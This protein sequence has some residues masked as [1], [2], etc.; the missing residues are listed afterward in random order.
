ML[1]P[2]EYLLPF[3]VGVKVTYIKQVPPGESI[4]LLLHVVP[5]AKAKLGLILR[6][7]SWS[8]VRPELVSVTFC[9]AL[10]VPVF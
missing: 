3:V 9:A 1:T 5:F 4:E 10:V 7:V 8:D 6:P 2:P